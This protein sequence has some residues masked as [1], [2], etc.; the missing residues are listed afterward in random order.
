M[1]FEK[2]IR[3]K[4]KCCITEK[5]LKDSR[6]INMIQL[7]IKASWDYPVWGSF[8]TGE[9]NMAVAYVHD[10]AIVEGKIVGDIKFMVEL[11]DG[12]V[13]HHTIRRCRQCGC[14]EEDACIHPDH[15]NCWWVEEDLCSHCKNWPGEAKRYSVIKAE[16][17]KQ[18]I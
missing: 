7:H 3:E 18:S 14:S 15:G 13:I 12:E 11:R 9:S 1:D 6:Y 2:L 17:K 8:I 10:D 16:K 4:G 5:P